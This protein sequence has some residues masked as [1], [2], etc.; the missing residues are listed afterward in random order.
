MRVVPLD[1]VK[2]NDV[3]A[4]SIYD[5]N[6]T[7]LLSAGVKLSE[8]FVNKLK[9]KG[10][11]AV[12]IRDG[13]TDDIEIEEAISE[14]TR[15]QA[16]AA[17]RE[18]LI[19]AEL[20]HDLSVVKVDGKRIKDVVEDIIDELTKK[21][22]HTIGL[23]DLKSFDDYL[24]YHSVSVTVLSL[25]VGI[26]MKL[27]FNQLLHL[28]TAS[29]FYDAGMIMVP[30][31]LQHKPTKLT[32]EEQEKV[33]KHT[34]DGFNMLRES[35]LLSALDYNVAYQHHER[36]NGSGYPKGK[37]GK[38]IH[39]FAKIVGCI[40]VYDALTSDRPFRRALLPY[41]A[42]GY[43]RNTAG[44]LFDKDVVDILSKH[45]SFYPVGTAVLLNT[46]QQ[47]I[48]IGNTTGNPSRPLVRVFTEL[49]N[50]KLKKL[51]DIDMTKHRSLKIIRV[52]E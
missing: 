46:G 12:Y 52:I 31:E 13:F 22:E 2:E 20:N 28:G 36:L 44:M 6:G 25:M 50:N 42:I 32:K 3:L 34:I 37:V 40:D 8:K 14:K 48:V 35:E 19:D 47:G 9:S 23:L 30:K 4:K 41:E 11:L 15:L 1:L 24:Y 45:V 27:N 16:L 38:E 33:K 39:L 10:F 18:T 51:K 7:M 43:L 29:M 49:A 26:A 17:V 5:V 21:P